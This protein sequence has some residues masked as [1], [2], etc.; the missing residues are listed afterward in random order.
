MS[1]IFSASIA[2]CGATR[3]N[4]GLR[5]NVRVAPSASSRAAEQRVGLLLAVVEEAEAQTRERG[6]T[7]RERG[8]GGDAAA[9]RVVNDD[10][11]GI[12][13]RAGLLY[14]PSSATNR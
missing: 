10:H 2:S 3:E 5:A 4:E 1:H 12:L 7:G 14:D 8:A 9:A 13:S 11:A 6:R